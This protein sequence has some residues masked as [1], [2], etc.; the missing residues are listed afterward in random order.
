[1]IGEL[2]RNGT[3]AVSPFAIRKLCM[4]TGYTN[5]YKQGLMGR[6]YTLHADSHASRLLPGGLAPGCQI[7][8]TMAKVGFFAVRVCDRARLPD[9]VPSSLCRMVHL[10]NWTVSMLWSNTPMWTSTLVYKGVD[11]QQTALVAWHGSVL[12][13]YRLCC[14]PPSCYQDSLPSSK[15]AKWWRGKHH[16]PCS[17]DKPNNNDFCS[18]SL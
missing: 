10:L 17:S 14:W 18:L 4:H 7:P 8:P 3:A 5:R 6:S 16:V 12:S 13:L 15:R 11:Q 2:T 9:L 1:M